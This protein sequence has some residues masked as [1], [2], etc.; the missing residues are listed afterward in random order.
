M[1]KPRPGKKRGKDGGDQTQLPAL[2]PTPRTK[3]QSSLGM[4]FETPQPPTSSM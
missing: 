4:R 1:A 2:P 3:Q